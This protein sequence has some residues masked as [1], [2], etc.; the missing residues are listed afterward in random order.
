MFKKSIGDNYISSYFDRRRNYNM[1][2]TYIKLHGIVFLKTQLE[3]SLLKRFV[4]LFLHDCALRS[5]S[6][7]S[8][9]LQALEIVLTT[10]VLVAM[11]IRYCLQYSIYSRS[12]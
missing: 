10:H 5:R 8:Y 4:S 11:E 7:Y 2:L 1:T 9:C 6:T 3:S 12:L